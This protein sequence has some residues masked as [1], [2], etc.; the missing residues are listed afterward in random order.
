ACFI[1]VTIFMGVMSKDREWLPRPDLNMLSWSFAFAVL[2]GFFTIFCLF[3]LITHYLSV[4]SKR[5][6]QDPALRQK[7]LAKNPYYAAPQK[8]ISYYD[9]KTT[10]TESKLGGGAGTVPSLFTTVPSTFVSYHHHQPGSQ[11][12]GPSSALMA[13]GKS[14]ILSRGTIAPGAV[15]GTVA[16][17]SAATVSA[18]LR[19]TLEAQRLAVLEANLRAAEKNE[20]SFQTVDN[21]YSPISMQSLHDANLRTE[22]RYDMTLTRQPVER[23]DSTTTHLQSNVAMDS[24]V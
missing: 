5:F 15:G 17:T 18:K 6:M 7:F 8:T 10:A 2:A 24:A 12:A 21:V 1:V 4:E 23:L 9:G 19:E 20:S 16:G 14:S 11:I 3:G 22:S 13:P